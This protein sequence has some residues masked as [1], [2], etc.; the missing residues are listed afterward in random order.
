MS[1]S[2]RAIVGYVEKEREPERK[3]PRLRDNANRVVSAVEGCTND[4]VDSDVGNTPSEEDEGETD[5]GASNE[6]QEAGGTNDIVDSE[7]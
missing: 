2:V 5:K 1:P 6:G 4:N 3:S 7:E